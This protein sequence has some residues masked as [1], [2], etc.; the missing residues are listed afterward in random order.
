MEEMAKKLDE[1]TA[2]MDGLS[3]KMTDT[4]SELEKLIA[5]FNKLAKSMVAINV[6]E[7][8]DWDEIKANEGIR[9]R[10]DS[11]G[12]RTERMTKRLHDMIWSIDSL[13]EKV[14]AME[15]ELKQQATGRW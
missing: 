9:A 14:H 11:M 8:G 1:L 12:R 6:N 3:L 4:T 15:E 5:D 7:A 10:I 2:R 13:A